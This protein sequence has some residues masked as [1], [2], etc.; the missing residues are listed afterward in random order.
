MRRALAILIVGSYA[1]LGVY[2]LCTGRPKTGAAGVLL[3]L[4]NVLLF[5]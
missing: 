5:F 4:V 1:A 3:S 2:D